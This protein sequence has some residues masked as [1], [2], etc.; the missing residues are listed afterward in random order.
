MSQSGSGCKYEGC[1][2]PL[3]G[4]EEYCIFHLPKLTNEQIKE[5][6]PEKALEYYNFEEE[7]REKFFALLNKINS[8]P[9]EKEFN[10]TGFQFVDINLRNENLK[11]KISGW[12]GFQKPVNFWEAI[13]QDID[14]IEVTFQEA[15]FSSSTFQKADFSGATFQEATFGHTTFQKANF[16]G[17]TFQT[18]YFIKVTF[19][20]ADFD[21]ATFQEATFGHTT[22]QEADFGW[23][24]FQEVDF[25]KATFHEAKFIGATFH[26]VEFDQSNFNGKV[27]FSN[28][29]VQ[30]KVTFRG[31]N[32][33]RVPMGEC[34]FN[35]IDIEPGAKIIFEKVNLEKASFLDANIENF[36]FR[37]VKWYRKKPRK[38]ALWD[39]FENKEV[40]LSKLADNYHQ[41]VLN[42]E[43]KREFDTALEFHIGEME[44]KRKS[45]G[46]SK[47]KFLNWVQRNALNLYA[48]YKY[49]S[50]YGTSYKQALGWLAVM[51][52]IFSGIFLFSGFQPA[53]TSNANI[54]EVVNYDLLSPN[55]ASLKRLVLDYWSALKFSFS[56]LTLQRKPYFEAMGSWSQTLVGCAGI[57][58]YSQVALLL[59]AIRRRFKQ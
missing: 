52:L 38:I 56:I 23:A 37:D 45:M 51:F 46:K 36:I 32:E 34:K 28:S 49:L 8:D 27:I 29:T 18:A 3:Y 44:V 48:W 21:R 22:F 15:W 16:I 47:N 24:T 1:P 25:F 41:L 33:N 42:Y 40:D 59:L 55:P 50:Y 4:K 35:S 20:K 11:E 30:K 13:L 17:A 26:K 12:D 43:K 7:F 31:S 39:E 10:F 14:F 6:T 5:L 53:S 58:F 57:F 9:E 54:S 19:Q 2:H